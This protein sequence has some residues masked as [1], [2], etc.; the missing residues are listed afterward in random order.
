MSKA[1]VVNVDVSDDV[2]GA[3]F[4]E[5]S[6]LGVAEMQ[7]RLGDALESIPDV[8]SDVVAVEEASEGVGGGEVEDLLCLG[9]GEEK[10][11]EGDAG[12]GGEEGAGR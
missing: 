5:V 1:N 10:P 2:L 12:G 6:H 4:G 7:G 9:A 8:L 11:E 3:S